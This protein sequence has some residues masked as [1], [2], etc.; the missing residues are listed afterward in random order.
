M[1]DEITETGTGTNEDVNLNPA[2]NDLLSVIPEDV[3]SEVIPHLQ[4]WDRGVQDRFQNVQSEW[5]DYGF[6]KEN[7]ISPD[8][9]RIALG[10][11]RAVQED[12][13][14]FYKSLQ[15]AYDFGGTVETDNDGETGQG[16]TEALNLPPEVLQR[17]D[18]LENQNKMMAEILLSQK[19]EREK[20]DQD[21]TLQN[22]LKT[23][24]TQH[25]KF[26]ERFVLAYMQNGMSGE[27]AIKQYQDLVEK[28]KLDNARPP[29]P[30]L[31]GSNS[32]GMPGE[33][34]VDPTKLDDSQTKSLVANYLKALNQ[35]NQ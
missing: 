5:S 27:D 31:L 18:G 3:H 30:R 21:A 33:R 14:N 1:G 32:G 23:L 4:N 34:P 6:L 29:A 16:G 9:T 26:D 24:E 13:E 2:W 7:E 20:A 11:L 25:G 17:L 28:V 22:E 8:D 10:L 35:S 15:E 19:E 12:P